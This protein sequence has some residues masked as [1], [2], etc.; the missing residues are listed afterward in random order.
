MSTIASRMFAAS[1]WQR[2]SIMAISYWEPIFT[3]NIEST[4]GVFGFESRF[5]EKLTFFGPIFGPPRPCSWP[6]GGLFP[7]SGQTHPAAI[8]RPRKTALRMLQQMLTVAIRASAR[9]ARRCGS[10]NP[11]ALSA[12]RTRA[13][14]RPASST[15]SRSRRSRAWASACPWASCGGS[16][17]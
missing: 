14:R 10:R 5:F 16:A 17:T 8:R 2:M 11:S 15:A 4:L 1:D 6:M 13:R 3:S 7:N 9:A 12:G